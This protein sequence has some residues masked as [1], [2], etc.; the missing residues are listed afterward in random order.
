M[1]VVRRPLTARGVVA[2]ALLG[3]EP[4]RLSA[5]RLVRVGELFGISSGAIRVAISRMTASGELEKTERGYELRGPLLDRQDRQR[6]ARRPSEIDWDGSWEIAVVSI[7]GRPAA[8]RAT[9]RSAMATLRLGELRDGVWLRPANLDP[10][11]SPAAR[12]RRDVACTMFAGAPQT[13]PGVLA[14]SLW[15]LDEW[16]RDADELTDSVAGLTRRLD[17]G[18]PDMLGPG[19]IESAAVL[20]LLSADPLLPAPLTPASTHGQRLRDTYD[21][22]DLAYR[23]ELRRWLDAP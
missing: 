9:L 19:F 21:A 15:D 8:E 7:S 12:A 18:D 20:R 6:S 13:S 5:R 1:S 10:E 17:D 3:T 16:A 2:S 14:R 22:F 4:P 11:R 23:R